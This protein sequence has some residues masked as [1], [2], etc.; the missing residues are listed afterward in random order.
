MA[1]ASSPIPPFCSLKDKVVIVTGAARGIGASIAAILAQ[2]GA[3]L[4]LGDI[5]EPTLAAT[6]KELAEKYGVKVV[7]VAGNVAS[8]LWN[9]VNLVC[10][11]DLNT[12]L[13]YRDGRLHQVS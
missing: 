8:T 13:P 10:S 4:V 1:V 3:N 2:A 11:C 12:D 9:L 7:P 5:D 6:A